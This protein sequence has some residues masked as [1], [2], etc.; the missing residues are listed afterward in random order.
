M[1]AAAA[2]ASTS[3]TTVSTT[4]IASSLAAICPYFAR[5]N[6]EIALRAQFQISLFQSSPSILPEMRTGTP[7][8]SNRAAIFSVRGLRDGC[9][10]VDDRAERIDT[11]GANF[12]GVVDTFLQTHYGCGRRKQRREQAR[13]GF[14]VCGFHAE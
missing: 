4:F 7:A 9:R 12:A 1:R 2:T 3:F 11:G 6:A 14:G 13:G 5:P 8:R 10:N